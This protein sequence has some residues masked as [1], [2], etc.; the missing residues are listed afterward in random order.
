MHLKRSCADKE[1]WSSK[2]LLLA[3]VAQDVADVL[4]EEAFD[5]L[6]KFRYA[7][8]IALVHLPLGVRTRLEGRN[9]AIDLVV[10]GD[11]GDQVLDDREGLHGKNGDGLIERKR[12]H[13]CF[14]GEPRPAIDLSGA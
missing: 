6:A 11:V 14:A 13:A 2:F 4:A 5:A 7:I 1:T 12:I 3:V 8:D 9:F 10:P